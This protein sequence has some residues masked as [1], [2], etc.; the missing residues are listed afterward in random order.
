M[1]DKPCDAL[2]NEGVKIIKESLIVPDRQIQSLQILCQAEAEDIRFVPDKMIHKF[3]AGDTVLITQ[4]EFRVLKAMLRIGM[5]N[6]ELQL[7]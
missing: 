5:G 7:S 4:G 3:K 6:N 2:L 1:K